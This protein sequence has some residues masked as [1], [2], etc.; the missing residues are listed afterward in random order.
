[1]A[2][3]AG[4]L[5]PGLATMLAVITTDASVAPATLD[6][7][8]RAATARTFDRLDSDGCMSTNDTVIAM[9]SGASAASWSV[10][11]STRSSSPTC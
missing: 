1:M 4:M 9:A 8:L 7:A 2:K 10:V 11:T 6:A 5:A 3:G